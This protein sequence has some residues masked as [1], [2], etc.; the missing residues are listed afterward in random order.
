MSRDRHSDR[1]PPDGQDAALRRLLTAALD[2]IVPP[3]PDPARARFRRVG[4]PGDLLLR[5]EILLGELLPVVRRTAVMAGA[6]VLIGSLALGP[7][8]AHDL[9]FTGETGEIS[10][11]VTD[12]TGEPLSGAE[13]RVLP[14]SEARIWWYARPLAS[15]SGTDGRF[16]IAG[17]PSGLVVVRASAPG[18]VAQTIADVEVAVART[19]DAAFALAPR[20]AGA[21]SGSVR[22]DRGVAL[23]G[24]LVRLSPVRGRDR[25]ASS[26]LETSAFDLAARTDAT[27][28]FG[29]ERVP[30]GEYVAS[31]TLDGF[32]SGARVE[33]TVVAET[34]RRVE[35]VLRRVVL[36]PVSP[37]ASP[38]PQRAPERHAPSVSGTPAPAP[39]STAPPEAPTPRPVLLPGSMGGGSWTGGSWGGWRPPRPTPTPTPRWR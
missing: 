29:I 31:I 37:V 5:V 23:P 36:Q 13:V 30:V 32:G 25:A 22:D 1:D 24:A 33:V 2:D 10:G 3:T 20:S 9:G 19:T 14:T 35:I 28:A 4:R 17:V 26:L 7:A 18:S 11:V 8:V 16:A 39:S 27:G 6:V 38:D 15:R 21:V 34:E 12:T